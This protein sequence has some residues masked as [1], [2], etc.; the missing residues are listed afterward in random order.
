LRRGADPLPTAH[1]TNIPAHAL[2]ITVLDAETGKPVPE[3]ELFAP[4]VDRWDKPKPRRFADGQGQYVLQAPLPPD[5]VR[6]DMSL[7][8][9]SAKLCPARR[10]LD[11][12]RR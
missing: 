1:G 4:N 3:A 6:R 9:I 10:W 2:T 8:T 11:R 7:F 5:K 12:F